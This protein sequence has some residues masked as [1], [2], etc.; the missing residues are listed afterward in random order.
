LFI[1]PT[2]G[3]ETLAG[4]VDLFRYIDSNFEHWNCNTVGPATKET[5]VQVH[6]IVRDSTFQEMFGSFGVTLD[7]AAIALKVTALASDG[8]IVR[9]LLYSGF[10]LR[11]QE[12]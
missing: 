4:A 8:I 7:F 1:S 6:Q 2:D 3:Q 12:T 9:L 11:E 5:A 10:A